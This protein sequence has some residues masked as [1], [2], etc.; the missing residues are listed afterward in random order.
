MEE[1]TQ[2]D[3]SQDEYRQPYLTLFNGVTD[4]LDALRRQNYGDAR[5]ILTEAQRRAEAEYIGRDTVLLLKASFRYRAQSL[6]NAVFSK[7][8]QSSF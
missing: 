2:T 1:R 3:R 5:D 7:R 4:A 8:I 6:G